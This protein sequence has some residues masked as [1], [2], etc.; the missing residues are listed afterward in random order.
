M[1][2]G[3]ISQADIEAG[4]DNENWSGW[5]YLQGRQSASV[6]RVEAADAAVVNAANRLGWSEEEFFAW[7]NSKRGRWAAD[8]L[9]HGSGSD[10]DELMSL[11]DIISDKE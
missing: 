9:I 8:S 3:Q 2:G 1:S 6:Q 7:M 5:G 10:I 11:E 4:Y